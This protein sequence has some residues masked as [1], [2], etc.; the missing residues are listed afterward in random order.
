MA[1]SNIYNLLTFEAKAELDALISKKE[2]ALDMM[3]K[4]YLCVNGANF[5]SE[6]ICSRM[7][8]Q[9]FAKNPYGNTTMSSGIDGWLQKKYTNHVR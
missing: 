6:D 9:Y 4:N 2:T 1:Y 3:V 8:V 7:Q 5:T